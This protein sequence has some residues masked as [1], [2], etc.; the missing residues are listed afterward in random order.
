MKRLVTLLLAAGL[1][2]AGQTPGH[3]I[4][5]KASGQWL[6]GFSMGE[7]TLMKNRRNQDG[8]RT[9]VNNQDQFAAQ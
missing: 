5:F 3:A 2:L 4:E 8:T 9:K 1:F 7:G 6:M